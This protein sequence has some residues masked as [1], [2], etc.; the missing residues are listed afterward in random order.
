MIGKLDPTGTFDGSGGRSARSRLRC[1]AGIF[2]TAPG[3][4]PIGRFPGSA[5]AA[6]SRH[7]RTS[8]SLRIRFAPILLQ[9][10]AVT[11]DVV[12][13]FHLGRRGLV[14]DADALYATL[15]LRNT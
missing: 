8:N 2:P 11:D 3:A 14:P 10:S 1:G 5:G 4:L 9:K 6:S 12:Q 7:S 13:P 15:M